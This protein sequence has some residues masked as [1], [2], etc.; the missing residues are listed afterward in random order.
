MSSTS[1]SFSELTIYSFDFFIVYFVFLMY[2]QDAQTLANLV[3]RK[4]GC[5]EDKEGT[6]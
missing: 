5:F 2:L 4:V 3:Q 1:Y 6:T